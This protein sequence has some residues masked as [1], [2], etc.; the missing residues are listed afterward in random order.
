[1]G[2]TVN[3]IPHT[4]PQKYAFKM[5]HLAIFALQ[6]LAAGGILKTE[7]FVGGLI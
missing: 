3:G 1:M 4:Y 5:S 6:F 2:N 7:F